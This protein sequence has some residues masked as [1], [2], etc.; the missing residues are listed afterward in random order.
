M[1]RMMLGQPLRRI[2]K[3]V[4]TGGL[5]AAVTLSTF[6]IL[7]ELCRLWYLAA[8]I[9]SYI[10][11]FFVNFFLQKFWTFHNTDKTRTNIQMLL[12]TFNS[13]INLALNAGF[14][15]GLVDVLGTHHI[16]AQV[17]VIGSLAVMNYMLYWLVIFRQSAGNT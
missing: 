1:C 9:L 7:T 10:A 2:S 17:L 5:A 15:Y 13:F 14:M 4:V 16:F 11:S 6:V 12:F 8:S 3:F